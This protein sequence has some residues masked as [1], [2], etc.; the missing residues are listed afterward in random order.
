MARES[1]LQSKFLQELRKLGYKCYKQQMNAT[2]RAGTP[3]CIICYKKFY[4]FCE[5]KK[6][7][8]APF[9]P[10]QKETLEELSK[11]TYARVVFPENFD[12]IMSELIEVKKNEDM[13]N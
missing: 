7:K 6:S 2:T 8:D 9:R 1:S 11:W 13:Q 3:D 5:F 12:I 4:G 10:G